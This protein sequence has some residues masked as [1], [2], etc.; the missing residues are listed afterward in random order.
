MTKSTTK[1][2][3]RQP[4]KPV[5]PG[6]KRAK[7]LGLMARARGATFEEIKR[8]TRWDNKTAYEGIRLVRTFSGYPVTKEGDTY[9]V[10]AAVVKAA[11]ERS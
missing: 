1:R 2:Q 8:A 9:H 3:R 7:I 10:P 11:E 6:T 4:P 5:R